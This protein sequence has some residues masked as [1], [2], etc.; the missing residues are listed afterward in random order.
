MT[1]D[2]EVKRPPASQRGVEI[3]DVAKRYALT[4]PR[5]VESRPNSE[6]LA[7][8]ARRLAQSKLKRILDIFGASIGIV[9]LSPLF[10]CVAIAI[11]AETRGSPL[12][13]QKRSGYRGT[14]FVIYKFR[15]MRVQEDGPDV[16]QARRD[17]DRITR[18]GLLL[19]RTS[20]DELPQ[21]LNVLKGDMSLVGPRPHAI[22]HDEY[23]G[24]CVPGYRSRFETKPG[25]TG[26][27]QV[28]GLRGQTKDI[29]DMAAR[30]AKDIEYIETWSFFLD[31]KI[32]CRTVFIFAF[33]P[34]AF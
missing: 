12:F 17:D 14:P 10:V 15:T 34:A 29:S 25:L 19:R 23:Y 26:L 9:V 24:A 7:A 2:S 21:L 31:V 6:S 32:L 8:G 5:D 16:I 18:V 1:V 13:R 28:S 11:A 33:H 27:A 20:V 22:A 30:V 4:M 3:D